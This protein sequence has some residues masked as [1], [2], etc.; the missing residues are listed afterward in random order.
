MLD[1]PA[2]RL[3]RIGDGRLEEGMP[4]YKP[5][6]IKPEGAPGTLSASPLHS[7]SLESAK[8]FTEVQ[9]RLSYP[10]SLEPLWTASE[11]SFMAQ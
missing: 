10:Y 3:L 8:L 4:S 5:G 7:S 9:R 11:N 6:S 2:V 1:L